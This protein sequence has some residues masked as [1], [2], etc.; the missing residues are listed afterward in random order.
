M[1]YSGD[2]KT[3]GDLFNLQWTNL[4]GLFSIIRYDLRKTSIKIYSLET[5]INTIKHL[6]KFFTTL[7][8]CLASLSCAA[9]GSLV[10]VGGNLSDDNNEIYGKFISLAGGNNARVGVITA[11]SREN[12]YKTQQSYIETFAQYGVRAEWI[13]IH[14]NNPDAAENEEILAQLRPLTGIFFGGGDQSLLYRLLTN[15]EGKDSKALKLIRKKHELGMPIGGTSAGAVIMSGTPHVMVTGGWPHK[16]ILYGSVPFAHNLE[17]G[18]LTYNPHGG[19]GFFPHG[20]LD[21]HL[22]ARTQAGPFDSS[23]I[24]Y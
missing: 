18:R 19:F 8:F 21:T 11:A 20:I 14:V 5:E 15:K 7:T 22:S 13:G 23:G 12:Y 3:S 4:I 24:G 10:L 9:S 16:S 17:P 6:V 2:V 1:E